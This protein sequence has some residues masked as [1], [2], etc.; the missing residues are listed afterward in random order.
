MSNRAL[1]IFSDVFL[2]LHPVKVPERS[3][4]MTVSHLI[5]R[6]VIAFE[7]EAT[8]DILRQRFLWIG[9]QEY[10]RHQAR[11]ARVSLAHRPEIQQC[12]VSLVEA[13]VGRI[14]EATL[15]TDPGEHVCLAEAI[16]RLF[17]LDPLR[18][19]EH[20]CPSRPA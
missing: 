20:S 16:S 4:V 13:V 5:V 14:R 7:M 17:D 11:L 9:V 12:A 15:P 18:K 10:R 6:E 3:R 1:A 19:A 2:H 8:L